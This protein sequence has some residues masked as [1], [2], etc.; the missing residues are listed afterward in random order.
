MAR[1]TNQYESITLEFLKPDY[2]YFKM[3]RCVTSVRP[4][5]EAERLG[6]KVGWLEKSNSQAERFDGK[7]GMLK[8]SSKRGTLSNHK[9]R[10][11]WKSKIKS[12]KTRVHFL[13]PKRLIFCKVIY[14][15]LA[16]THRKI[17]H[18]QRKIVGTVSIG[19][20]LL[21]MDIAKS[22]ALVACPK[23]GWNPDKSRWLP[24][25]QFA[26]LSIQAK[27]GTKIL[28]NLCE[29]L[30]YTSIRSS[31]STLSSTR[32]ATT[33]PS[34]GFPSIHGRLPTIPQ[35]EPPRSGKKRAIKPD[36]PRKQNT[37]FSH[38]S[39]SPMRMDRSSTPKHSTVSSRMGKS[40]YSPRGFIDME[41]EETKKN[42]VPQN[43]IPL[44]FTVE[45]ALS[46][47]LESYAMTSSVSGTNS[48]VSLTRSKTLIES[49]RPE[50]ETDHQRVDEL[51]KSNYLEKPASVSDNEAK[52][53]SNRVLSS[54]PGPS[55]EEIQSECGNGNKESLENNLSVMIPN[56]KM[57]SEEIESRGERI[58]LTESKLTPI[59]FESK[60]TSKSSEVSDRRYAT[61][62]VKW[63]TPE[64][65]MEERQR[66]TQCYESSMSSSWREHDR[67][68]L[69]RNV[70]YCRGEN[71]DQHG[72][73]P[74]RVIE[75]TSVKKHRVKDCKHGRLIR[76]AD[77]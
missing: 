70:S 74:E 4:G 35:T 13:L 16:S 36:F 30:L 75:P 63:S 57:R 21:V 28:E 45:T 52:L 12:C 22:R 23:S 71:V 18:P 48:K 11:R 44:N 33:C 54:L 42:T 68:P 59:S 17:D 32:R 47:D 37:T 39:P 1:S 15:A 43:I 27:D 64:Q 41:F 50:V 65:K 6:V 34:L 29:S 69:G 5:S 20:V 77:V 14:R 10:R 9:K 73:S 53:K 66:P 7:A 25:Q 19:T 24:K 3:G 51:G 55:N 67:S 60:Y 38:L 49:W 61:P 62:E 76:R 46:D 58:S 2:G 26:W 8:E 31:S 72:R 56:S 40:Q